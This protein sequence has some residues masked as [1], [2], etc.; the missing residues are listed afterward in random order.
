M[1]R[2]TGAERLWALG[3]VGV[4]TGSQPFQQPSRKELQEKGIG[5]RGQRS[6][7]S[8]GVVTIHC[9]QRHDDV[10]RKGRLNS[11]S[12]PRAHLLRNEVEAE[13]RLSKATGRGSLGGDGDLVYEAVSQGRAEG[14]LVDS[15]G[16]SSVGIRALYE[17]VK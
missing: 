4:P 15:L 12:H 17:N 8:Y 5:F 3:R 9:I 6:V 13:Q 7:P 1:P 10:R 2:G 16:G 14:H 11:E